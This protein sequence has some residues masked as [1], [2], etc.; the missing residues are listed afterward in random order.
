[1]AIT[2]ECARCRRVR[3]LARATCCGGHQVR[4]YWV[5]VCKRIEGEKVRYREAVG[6]SLKAAR[7]REHQVVVE[8]TESKHLPRFQDMPL[9]ALVDWYLA[10]PD[11][12]AKRSYR[13]DVQC[14][15]HPV[16]Q[17]GER[18]LVGTLGI[19]DGQAYQTTRLAA[20]AAPGTVNRE[21]SVVK[22]A[23]NKAVE[24]G[25][26]KGNPLEGLRPC[27]GAHARTRVATEDE[28]TRILDAVSPHV[29]GI[30]QVA[31][32]LGLRERE[33]LGLKWQEIDFPGRFIRLPPERTKTARG[34]VVPIPDDVFELFEH[35]RGTTNSDNVFEY[36]GRPVKCIDRAWHT[37]LQRAGV[38]DLRFHDLRR[39]AISNLRRA[40]VDL[41]T[42]MAVSGHRSTKVFA[43]YNVVDENDL[44]QVWAKEGA[45]A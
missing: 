40:G 2:W 8:L 44:A 4:Q 3:S 21:V 12:K 24:H 35:L 28:I 6:P 16:D 1:M 43:S 7:A 11:V 22:A 29:L 38:K 5:D 14:L 17:W 9:G 26:I 42:I 31:H 37:A 18:R 41:L 34:R 33:I 20:G 27:P 19:A 15:R 39:T 30:I 13:R 45:V 10:L 32:R 23:F 36:E 25:H